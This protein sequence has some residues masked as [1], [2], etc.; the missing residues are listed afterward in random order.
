MNH[1]NILPNEKE[2]NLN[3]QASLKS[4]NAL[5][6]HL[7]PLAKV[8][9]KNHIITIFTDSGEKSPHQFYFQPLV[10]LD[11]KSTVRESNA[12][13]KQELVRFSVQMWNQELR[14]KV[15]ERL[16]SLPAL[17]NLIIQEDDVNVMP[18]EEVQLIFKPDGVHHES[19]QLT[20]Q[21]TPYILLSETLDFYSL[22]D[23]APTA[24]LLA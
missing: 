11:P 14:S 18:Y 24:N 2:G 9:Y 22:C 8:S 5:Q 3:L 19:I 1:F 20:K 17:N 21:A 6:H 10:F 12:F 7:V 13:L 23:S 16:R 4:E 15:L